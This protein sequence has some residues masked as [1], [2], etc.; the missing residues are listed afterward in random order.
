MPASKGKK[1][2]ASELTQSDSSMAESAVPEPME[3]AAAIMS[4][5]EEMP[6]AVQRV[7]EAIERHRD[8]KCLVIS[9]PSHGIL[10]DRLNNWLSGRYGQVVSTSMVANDKGFFLALFYEPY[11]SS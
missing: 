3:P 9:A 2:M 5:A 7:I 4:T 8:M 10:Q 1:R 6:P 11:N